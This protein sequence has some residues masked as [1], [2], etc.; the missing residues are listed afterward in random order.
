M[1]V[2]SWVA[3]LISGLLLLLLAWPVAA[4]D[5]A[6]DKGKARAGKNEPRQFSKKERAR[7]RRALEREL[8]RPFQKWLKEDVAYI[9]TSEERQAFKR[10]QNAEERE[11]FIEQFWLRRDPTPDSIENEYKEE[12][13]R[14]IA[15]ANQHFASGFQGWKSDRGRIYIIF[16]PPDERNQHAGGRYERRIA[17]GGGSTQAYPF[18]TW[19]YRHI[20]DIGTNIEIEFVDKTMTGEFRMAM[21]PDEKDALLHLS[22]AGL[23][24]LEQMGIASKKDRLDGRDLAGTGSPFTPRRS[25]LHRLE[26]FHRLQRPSEG[27]VP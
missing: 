20:E 1:K 19:R 12:I 27:Q 17:E 26:E 4:K 3:L 18:E 10:L 22:G 7:R 8:N 24:L 21:G 15:Y 9:I 2:K 5:K 13:Y 14:R 11:Q 23:T 6:K 16:G 25:R